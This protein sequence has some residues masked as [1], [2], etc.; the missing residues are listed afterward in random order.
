MICL[1]PQTSG[2][3]LLAVRP[4]RV[5]GLLVS[6]RAVNVPAVAIGSCR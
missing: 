6:L 5:D 4:D 3:L 1:D 2:G